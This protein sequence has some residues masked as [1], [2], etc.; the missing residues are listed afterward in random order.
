M[1]FR[2]ARSLTDTA[3]IMPHPAPRSLSSPSSTC[4]YATQSCS[5]STPSALPHQPDPAHLS[6]PS[7]RCPLLVPSKSNTRE[8]CAEAPL[9]AGGATEQLPAGGVAVS[10]AGGGLTAVPSWL[11]S[12]ACA[13]PPQEH[14]SASSR[15]SAR[16]GGPDVRMPA[17]AW[18]PLSAS[19]VSVHASGVRCPVSARA[20]SARPVSNVWVSGCP[21]SGVSSVGVRAFRVRCVRTG[22]FVERV[23]GQPHGQGQGHGLAA[24][25]Y[26]RTARATARARAEASAPAQAVLGQRRRRLDLVVVVEALGQRTGFDRM[27]GQGPPVEKDRP[28]VWEQV[29]A[30]CTPSCGM[31]AHWPS[32]AGLAACGRP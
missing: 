23:G 17:V 6:F 32:G 20:M 30:L 8:Q 22:D 2:C 4:T 29:C 13:A 26:P 12:A 27:A 21:L 25:P 5:L 24:L 14:G 16:R 7:S 15:S 9:T 10:R 1:L 28:S 18:S 11:P 19:S 31:A 3:L